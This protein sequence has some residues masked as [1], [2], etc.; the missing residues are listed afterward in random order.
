MPPPPSW[1][2]DT[3]DARLGPLL[4]LTH[5]RCIFGIVKSPE[6]A[7]PAIREHLLALA[8]DEG[9]TADQVEIIDFNGDEPSQEQAQATNTAR[10]RVLRELRLL[11]FLVPDAE[12]MRI[13]LRCTP[14]LNTTP[15]FQIEV[16]ARP[17]ELA[18]E[19]VAAQI[20]ALMKTLH[21]N[22]DLLGLL[23][24]D[25]DHHEIPL[26]DLYLPLVSF[27]WHPWRIWHDQNDTLSLFPEGPPR[28][29]LVLGNPGSGKTTALRHLALKAAHGTPDEALP[30]HRVAVLLPLA[31]WAE[32]EARDRL[33]DLPT[34]LWTWL[35][36]RGVEGAEG[37]LD[38][39]DETTL[40]LDGLDEVRSASFRHHVLDQ[41]HQ[42]LGRNLACAVIAARPL[43]LDTP[44]PPPLLAELETVYLRA[45]TPEEIARFVDTFGRARR[46]PEQALQALT[47]QLLQSPPLR[48]L[49]STPLVLAFLCVLDELSGRLPE[50]RVEIYHRL[51][52]LLV[53]RWRIARSL[54]GGPM[55]RR[56]SR[57]D[58]LRVLG[59]LAFWLLARGGAPV[60]DAELLQ[61]LTSLETERG[62]RVAAATE[63]ARRLL[64]ILK[65]DTALLQRSS[66]GRWSFVHLSLVEYF[67]ALETSSDEARWQALLND[68]FDPDQREVLLLLAGYLAMIEG[69]ISRLDAL[70]DA[71]L[72]HSRRRGVYPASMPVLL[73]ALVRDLSTH[74][75]TRHLHAFLNRIF[76]FV[77]TNHFGDTALGQVQDAMTE[78]MRFAAGSDLR[79]PMQEMARRWLVPPRREI[80][81]ERVTRT[82]ESKARE[83][84]LD[85]SNAIS[86]YDQIKKSW[87][88]N[89]TSEKADELRNKAP[90]LSGSAGRLLDDLPALLEE[91]GVEVAPEVQA[92][93]DEAREATRPDAQFMYDYY[94]EY[95]VRTFSRRSQRSLDER[96]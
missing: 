92:R 94:I 76:E 27:E 26:A 90:E 88:S 12:R 84:A 8:V 4:A 10:P 66:E 59:P 89:N 39:L 20:A 87:I 62:E 63:R 80:R 77:L 56:P 34:F 50:H 95:L 24:H 22:V 42:I 54:A 19:E 58:I 64:D 9:A 40:L 37:I 73:I 3:L 67:A 7:W 33:L 18:W 14:D 71:V 69:R 32:I 68:P 29:W 65:T 47:D 30:P 41:V 93:I 28:A 43:V 51:A 79:A 85:A 82:G 83:I 11:A 38:H 57:G 72:R 17:T 2:L 15:D 21:R 81:W 96:W 61:T 25:T 55:G 23:P 49:A 1:Q 31:E 45:P 91:L 35:K 44:H 16:Q 75:S 70:C 53:E 52:D 13:L 78:L 5:H 48:S 36:A 6:S 74:L 60:P 46:R 86:I